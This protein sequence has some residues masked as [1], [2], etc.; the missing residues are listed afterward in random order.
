VLV[1]RLLA[2]ASVALLLMPAGAHLFELPGKMALSPD[3][4]MIVQRIYTGWALFG[5]AILAALAMT[6]WHTYLVRTDRRAFVLS[7]AAFLL[8]VA[9]QAIFWAFTFPMNVASRNWTL[10]PPDL[11]VARLQWEYSHAANALL[12]ICA[13]VAITLA[14][15]VH[16]RDVTH[17]AG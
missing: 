10:P 7:F 6:A 8:I 5:I 13:F 15:L 11:Q 9:T 14:V 4:Y 1:L 16:Q 3:Q 2:I 12:T 17:P